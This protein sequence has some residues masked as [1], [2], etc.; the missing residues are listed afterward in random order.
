MAEEQFDYQ[1]QPAVPTTE[2]STTPGAVPSADPLAEQ[3]Q[4]LQQDPLATPQD[5]ASVRERQ[6]FSTYVQN[7]GEKIPDNFND[8]GAWFD[9]LKEAQKNYTQGQQEIS[10]LKQ[11]YAENNTTNPNYVPEQAAPTEEVEIDGTEELRIPSPSEQHEEY[12][13][14]DTPQITEE[15]WSSWGMEV[16]V[17][18]NLSSETRADIKDKSGFTDGMIDDFMDGQKAKMREAYAESTKVVGG[19]ARLDNIFKWAAE[20]LSYEEQVQINFGLSGPTSE[21]TLR[22]LNQMYEQAIGSDAKSKEPMTTPNMQPS[23]VTQ[24]GYVGYKTKRE[25]Y[26]DRN[27]PRFRVEPKFR[28]AVEQRMRHTDFNSLQN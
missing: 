25:F 19:K 18:G 12:E 15:D 2:N 20:S 1:T 3:V 10:N 21:V 24:T 4:A 7:S 8:A 23:S 14:E 28:E 16:A 5:I 17:N 13:V 11:E 22:G 6:A 9:S 26:I 27:N